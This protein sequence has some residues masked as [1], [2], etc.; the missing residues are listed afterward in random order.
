[1]YQVDKTDEKILGI[2]TKNARLSVRQ[3]SKKC[4]IPHAT[5]NKRMRKMEAEGIIEG[6]SAIVN[7][8]KLGIETMAYV[9]IR[10]KTEADYSSMMKQIEKREEVEDMSALAGQFDL[11]LKVRVKTIR[12]LDDFVMQYIRK[13]PEVARTQTLIVF[14]HWH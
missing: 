14:R 6:Y 2:I 7:K 4:G 11:I 13:F 1:M 9:L 8:A 5:V 10:I 3:I 12:E